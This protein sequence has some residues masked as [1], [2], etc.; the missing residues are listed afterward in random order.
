MERIFSIPRSRWKET[1]ES[2]GLTFHSRTSPY[3]TEDAYYSFTPEE[4]EMFEKAGNETHQLCLEAA[5]H[6]IDNDLFSKLSI[7]KN[8][9]EVIVDSWEKDE[10]ELYGRFD[11]IY[12]PERGLKMIEYN[13]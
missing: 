7:P 12:F 11:F 9:A 2:Q 13:L 6:I 8:A 3:W 5:Q 10:W 1:V 4:I